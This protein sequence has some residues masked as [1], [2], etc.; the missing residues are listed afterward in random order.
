VS[1]RTQD[2][3]VQLI[4]AENC[5]HLAISGFGEINGQGGRFEY[6]PN[7][8]GITRPHLIR[9]IHCQDVTIEQVSL[10][11]AGCWMQN[12]LACDRLK[13]SGVHVYNR[14]QEN[15]DALDID[16]CKDVS[17]SD[18]VSDSEDDGITLKSTSGRLCENIAVTNCLLSSRWSAI[19]LGTE[20][21][22]GFKNVVISNCVVRASDNKVWNDGSHDDP[23]SAISLM[24][25][26]GGILEN[27]SISN[28]SIDNSKSPIYIRLG[29]RARPFKKGTEVKQVGKVSDI[30]IDNVR[31]TN[32]GNNGCSIT[33]LP[34]YPIER[35]RLSN[36]VINCDG[37]GTKDFLHRE[38]PEMP[39]NYPTAD[40]SNPLP[41]FGFFVRHVNHITFNGIEFYTTTSDQRPA[42]YLD[43]TKYCILSNLQLPG[44]EGN[45]ASL[46]VKQS[47]NIVISD[48]YLE[49]KSN[50][51]VYIEGEKSSDI[52]LLNNI[53]R[54]ANKLYRL[55]NIAGSKVMEK[56]N[57]K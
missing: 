25:V 19:K 30:T 27:V 21:N 36:I 53:L 51:F 17:V 24:I 54:N 6:H 48:C 8:E 5:H 3:T 10:K 2:S 45:E 29:D 22:G 43:D 52:F 39:K 12:Y 35:V 44:G 14:V 46:W 38:I 33:G 28:I 7:D 18:F 26:D 56:G 42:I 32:C 55:A 13:I 49:G 20:T 16:G 57:F 34:G 11:N 40:S 50:S 1:L 23:L 15:N 47:Q 37:G 41:A 4:F 31:I 9:F